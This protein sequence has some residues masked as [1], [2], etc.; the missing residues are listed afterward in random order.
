MAEALWL[1]VDD[2]REMPT[3]FDYHARTAAE[4]IR[5]L[6]NGNVRRVSLDHDLGGHENGTGYEVAKWIEAKAFAWS[7]G[8]EG[9]LPPLEWS[10]HSQN[11]VGVGNMTQAL[12]KCG[13]VLGYAAITG[14]K[15]RPH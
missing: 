14:R 9:G 1:W 12:Q 4:A 3:G 2:V 8:E 10:I 11:P 15:K 13:S 6:A 5:L 7:Q